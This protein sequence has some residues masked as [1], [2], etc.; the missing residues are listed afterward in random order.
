MILK[1]GQICPYHAKAIL[2]TL[3]LFNGFMDTLP[4]FRQNR[5]IKIFGDSHA[6]SILTDILFSRAVHKIISESPPEY[7]RVKS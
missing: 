7:R 4:A 2:K 3:R 1:N 6:L 5:G